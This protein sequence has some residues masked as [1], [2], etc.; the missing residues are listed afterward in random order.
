MGLVRAA[1]ESEFDRLLDRARELLG[2]GDDARLVDANLAINQALTLRPE[3]VDGWLVKCQVASATN[4]DIAALA[5]A[6][7]AHGRA[8]SRVETLYWRGAV[9][10]DLG[11]HRESLRSIEAAFRAITADDH[12][13][14]E[15]LY[16][17]KAMILDALGLHEAAVVTCEAGLDR[18]PG[19][20]LLRAALIPAE[21]ARVR[22]SLK[23]L[24]GGRD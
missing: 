11:R 6:E 2:A 15:D 1:Y 9:L 24:R 16:Y 8:P 21:R 5:A 23:L 18:C 10:G 14:L 19:S 20:A 22:S 3:S 17:E 7:M 13:M 4:D 12:W